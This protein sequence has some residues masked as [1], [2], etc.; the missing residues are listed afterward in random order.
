MLSV[1]CKVDGFGHAQGKRFKLA[2]NG[3]GLHKKRFLA[4]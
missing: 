3:G 4:E 2:P 1:Q